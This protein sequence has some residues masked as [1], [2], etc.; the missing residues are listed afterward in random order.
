MASFFEELAKTSAAMTPDSHLN[1]R[2][3]KVAPEPLSPPKPAQAP[4]TRQSGDPVRSFDNTIQTYVASKKL[5]GETSDQAMQRLM[6]NRD[7]T[8]SA[9]YSQRSKVRTSQ[10]YNVKRIGKHSEL[11]NAQHHEIMKAAKQGQSIS[12]DT[13]LMKAVEANPELYAEYR[14]QRNAGDGE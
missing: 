14:R 7:P 11:L 13:A 8:L 5:K 12:E 3:T 10:A 4:K 2:I 1:S 6:D 9:L